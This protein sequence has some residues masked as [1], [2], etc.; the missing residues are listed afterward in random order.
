MYADDVIIFAAL[1]INEA[2]VIAA[3]LSIFGNAS[4]L[5]TNLAKCIITP[6]YGADEVI[7]QI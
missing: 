2:Q 5:K 4:G 1:M 3:V 7:S 6:I